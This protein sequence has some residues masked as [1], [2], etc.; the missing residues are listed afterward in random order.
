MRF[1]VYFSLLCVL[2]L[3][4]S[5][6]SIEG[7]A[8]PLGWKK[9]PAKPWKDKPCCPQASTLRG[10]KEMNLTRV[11]PFSPPLTLPVFLP[12]ALPCLAL[13]Y[14]V[15]FVHCSFPGRHIKNCRRCKSKPELRF[16]IVPGALPQV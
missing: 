11:F 5:V 16:W 13:P 1:L 8:I 2:L 12:L 14:L 4:F 3:C 6:F 9:R 15:L 7:K 10:Q